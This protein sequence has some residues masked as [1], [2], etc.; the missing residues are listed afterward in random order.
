MK[1]PTYRQALIQAWHITWHNKILWI[2]GLLSIFLGQFGFSDIFGRF[3]LVSAG[4]GGVGLVLPWAS[5]SWPGG[6][7][8]IVGAFWIGLIVVS[9]GVFLVFLSISSQ[10]ALISYSYEWFKDKGYSNSSKSWRRSLKNFWRLFGVQVIRK[11]LLFALLLMFA[12]VLKIFLVSS[13]TLASILFALSLVFVLLL[14]LLISI[15]FVFTSCYVVIDGKGI[16]SALGKAWDLLSRHVLV[17]FE[18]GFLLML[19]NFVLIAMILFGSFIVFLPSVFIWLLAGMTNI[20][21]LVT[22]GY[23]VGIFLWIVLV[24]FMAAFFNAFTTSAWVFLFSKMHHEGISSRLAHWFRNL[25]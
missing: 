1:E 7:W 22:L 6:S 23:V 24:V 3:W 5:V 20:M 11:V 13:L 10:G 17:S 12:Y 25:V 9:L 8:G 15:L 16:K 18:V 21:G 4:N 2:L 14:S 19:F